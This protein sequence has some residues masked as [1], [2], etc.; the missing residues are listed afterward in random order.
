MVAGEFKQMCI[1]VLYYYCVF[2]CLEFFYNRSKKWVADGGR[3]N[4]TAKI[5]AQLK[6]GTR[7]S[8]I[9]FVVVVPSEVAVLV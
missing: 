6:T 3:A 9:K 2:F 5:T 1:P 8:L 4:F 7:S